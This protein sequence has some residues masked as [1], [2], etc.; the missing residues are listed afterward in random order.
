ML[1]YACSSSANAFACLLD[2]PQARKHA[3]WDAMFSLLCRCMERKCTCCLDV[4][5]HVR[6][7]ALA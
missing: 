2:Q 1:A 5:A 4:V 3:S 6:C 7:A